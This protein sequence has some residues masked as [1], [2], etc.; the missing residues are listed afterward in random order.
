MMIHVE[1]RKMGIPRTL[2]MRIPERDAI[3]SGL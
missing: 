1:W 3:V 2:P